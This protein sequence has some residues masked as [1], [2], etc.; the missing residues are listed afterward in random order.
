MKIKHLTCK[1]SSNGRYYYDFMFVVACYVY[2]R[3]DAESDIC[4][5]W[6]RCFSKACHLSE[7]QLVI[8][9]REMIS[10]RSRTGQE[11]DRRC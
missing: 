11:Q 6:P 7:H 1:C 9:R 8:F 10:G 4:G 5:V 3:F 2:R